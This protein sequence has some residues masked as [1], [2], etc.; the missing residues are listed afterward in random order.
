[1]LKVLEILVIMYQKDLEIGSEGFL[2]L[3]YFDLLG[4]SIE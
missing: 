3:S 1:M 2:A 4:G